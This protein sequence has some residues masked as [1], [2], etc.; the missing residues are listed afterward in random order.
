MNRSQWKFAYTAARLAEAAKSKAETHSGKKEWWEKEK[1]KV[2]DKIKTE[3]ISVHESV[4]AQY[5]TTKGG[6]G[7]EIEVDASLSRDLAECHSKIREHDGLIRQY[8]GWIQV[9]DAHPEARVELDH[10]DYL[11]FYG[12]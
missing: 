11:F 3:G 6:Y 9:L 5:S 2:M 10:D 12:K 1:A 8:D 7:P 4:G